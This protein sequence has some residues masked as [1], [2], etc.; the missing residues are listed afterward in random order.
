MTEQ[1]KNIETKS[2]LPVGTLLQGGKYRIERYLSSGGFG[3]TYVANIVE[4]DEKVA[5]KEFFMK[6]V[7]ERDGHSSTISVSNSDNTTLF[8][9]QKEK[10]KK[11][12]RRLRKL[13]NEHIVV[14]HDLFEE[15]GSSYY[16]M[17]YIQGES[18][19]DRMKR[20]GQ[21][22]GENEVLRILQQV[23]E[24]LGYVHAHGVYHLDL[25]P[26]NIMVDSNG[27]AKLI[28]FG[29]S[30]QM[31][32]GEGVSLFTSSAM[33]YTPGYAPLEQQEQSMKNLGPWTDIYAL[34][35]TLY[36]ILTNQTPPSA[37]ELLI[38]REPLKY[39]VP[40][41]PK[42]QQLI[43]WMMKP[44]YD[45]RPQS[46]GEIKRFIEEGIADEETKL[47]SEQSKPKPQ[48]QTQDNVLNSQPMVK[49]EETVVMEGSPKP[50]S[51]IPKPRV[52][53]QYEYEEEESKPIAL[54]IGIGVAAV[55][56]VAAVVLAI[57]LLLPLKKTEKTAV[58]TDSSSITSLVEQGSDTDAPSTSIGLPPPNNSPEI[59]PPTD[60]FEERNAEK[61]RQEEADKQRREQQAKERAEQE[62]IAQERAEKERL[63]REEA[64]RKRQQQTQS[65]RS[66]PNNKIFDIVEQQPTFSE[67]NP[68]AWLAKHMQYPPNAAE[69]GIQGRVTVGFVVEKNGTISN[70]RVLRGVEPSLDKEAVRVVKSMP[71][72]NPGMQDG[73]PVR[74]NYSVPI[75]FK[76]Q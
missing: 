5:V 52:Q 30:K 56:A 15:N 36:K 20:T 73:E 24:A 61:L 42:M 44:R 57:F 22:I 66:N 34:G 40:V 38:A 50:P 64:E 8:N 46:V 35:A 76:L 65:E 39:P 43:A 32:G 9:E 74:V 75:N 59:T 58:V 72:W 54:Y 71:R 21:T 41:S 27:C 60:N 55:A 47:I 3:N 51:S 31:H 69:N 19:S 67:G 13:K 4:F 18:L 49:N 1:Q 68:A 14:V 63:E 26:A 37:S 17:D 25:K 10:F 28:D 48:L 62:A 6:G 23:I 2:M 29:A 7:T 45:E 70:V 33:T 11:E 12:A 16:V 53:A